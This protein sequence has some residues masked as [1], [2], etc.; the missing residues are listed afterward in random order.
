[1]IAFGALFVVSVIGLAIVTELY[2]ERGP[3]M[4]RYPLVDPILGGILGVVEGMLLIGVLILVLDSYFLTPDLIVQR[5]RV[6]VR[7]R[8]L[9]RDGPLADRR[10]L[11]GDADPRLL[12]RASASS[13]RSTSGRSTHADGR[14]TEPA[15]LPARRPRAP[16]ARGGARPARRAPRA[17]GRRAGSARVGRIVEVEAYIGTERPRLAC[18]DGP[19]RAQPADVRARRDRL[20]LLRL[21]DVP[22]PQRRDRGGRRRS[23]GAGP[24]GRAARGHRTGCA[25]RGRQRW[26]AGGRRRARGPSPTPGWPPAPGSSPSPS[27]SPAPTPASTSATRRLPLRLEPGDAADQVAATAADRHRLRSRAVVESPLARDRAGQSLALSH[28]AEPRAARADGRAGPSRSSS[29]R[30]SASGSPT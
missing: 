16:D 20:R 9:Q 25:R 10:S 18:P 11:P 4:P 26:P 17:R 23:G 21:R 28:V 14:G 12:R 2:Y 24:R 13:S 15:R 19:D 27:T 30:R 3:F 6:R 8:L 7:A 22:L 1:M 5:R 29:S